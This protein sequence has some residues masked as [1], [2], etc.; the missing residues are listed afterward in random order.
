MTLVSGWEGYSWRLPPADEPAPGEVVLGVAVRALNDARLPWCSHAVASAIHE[1]FVPGRGFEPCE[2]ASLLV[3]RAE[4]G[5]GG[6]C[7]GKR[8]PACER[9]VHPDCALDVVNLLRE[10]ATDVLPE[11]D[12]LESELRLE[13]PV[14]VR[15][16]W[17]DG[18]GHV[19]VIHGF[20]RVGAHEFLRTADNLSPYPNSSE[21]SLTALRRSYAGTTG[22][23][24][25]KTYYTQKPQERPDDPTKRC[26]P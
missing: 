12:R 21:Y 24:W 3:A 10:P 22:G 8:A 1:F 6:D 14:A 26:C 4:E 20:R 18:R 25:V 5:A 9:S 13:Q 16:N 23:S 11:I 2:I 17:S 7:F 15:F 19:F